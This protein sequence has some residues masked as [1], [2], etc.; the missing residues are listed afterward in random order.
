[1]L[2]LVRNIN[3]N[4][5]KSFH[6]RNLHQRPDLPLNL[7][8]KILPKATLTLN[9]LCPSRINL[10]LLAHAQIHGSF[11][12]DK[13]PLAPPGI[14]FLTHKCA[15]VR[16]YFSFRSTRDYYVGPC[17][18]HYRCYKL[19]IPTTNSTRV[20][21]T[22]DW[23]PHKIPMPIASA[24]DILLATEKY[25]TES[26]CQ[27]QQNP[28]LPPPNTQTR[29]ALVKLNEIFPMSQNQLNQPITIFQGCQ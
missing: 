18:N 5:Q 20:T 4:F 25:L 9:L 29:H 3:T 7:W 19:W 6:L 11:N 8:D 23:F 2:E 16:E 27:S 21:N 1:M 13:T 24:N 15:K 17:L 10:Q 14:K 28:L 22:I 26:L 12:F